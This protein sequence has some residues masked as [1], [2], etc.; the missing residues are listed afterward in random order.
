[1]KRCVT[2]EELYGGNRETI[3]KSFFSRDSILRWLVG[4]YGGRKREYRNIFD[5]ESYPNL[6]KIEF[7][8]PLEAEKLLS[9]I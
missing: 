8:T 9:A 5:Q 1:M 2:K 7:K 6:T 3:S 4:T